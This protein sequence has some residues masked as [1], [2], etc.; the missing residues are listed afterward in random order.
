MDRQADLY[1]T[2]PPE[3]VKVT[4]SLDEIMPWQH[5]PHNWPFVK[6]IHLSPVPGKRPVI[7]MFDAIYS[8]LP[9]WI[10]CW[11]NN[12]SADDIGRSYD[13]NV[14]VYDTLPKANKCSYKGHRIQMG[15]HMRSCS[16]YGE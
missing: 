10:S 11:A 9:K 2:I 8:L 16:M 7:W 3:F 4:E 14:N 5:F 1:A 12:R 13:L 6:A 15:K